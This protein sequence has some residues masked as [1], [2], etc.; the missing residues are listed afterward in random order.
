[1]WHFSSQP[2]MSVS[3]MCFQDPAGMALWVLQ[4]HSGPPSVYIAVVHKPSYPT[5]WGTDDPCYWPG[6]SC[7]SLWN[8]APLWILCY[9]LLKS[10]CVSGPVHFKPMLFKGK[11]YM[12][13]NL[14]PFVP[15]VLYFN[16]IPLQSFKVYADSC[17]FTLVSRYFH[18][19]LKELLTSRQTNK[20]QPRFPKI[21][22]LMK[23]I[24]GQRVIYSVRLGVW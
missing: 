21:S 16:W 2:P 7:L 13:Y 8:H 20:N 6:G 24:L 18:Y 23:M 14:D 17:R 4:L 11:L 9:L 22:Y 1:M 12:V 19:T 3:H 5:H 15:W 10:I